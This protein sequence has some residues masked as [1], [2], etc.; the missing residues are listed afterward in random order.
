MTV[1]AEVQLW[2]LRASVS[3]GR[4][5]YTLLKMLTDARY[6]NEILHAYVRPFA[7]ASGSD[8]DFMDNDARYKGPI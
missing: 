7:G 4:R 3:R 1:A 6:L 2:C 5:T 8:F